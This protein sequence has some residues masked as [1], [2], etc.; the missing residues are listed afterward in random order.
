MHWACRS[1]KPWGGQKNSSNHLRPLFIY[2]LST[3]KETV[4]TMTSSVGSGWSFSPCAAPLELHTGA[5]LWL[6]VFQPLQV[7]GGDVEHD[8]FEPQD[9]KEALREGAVT[10]ALPIVACLQ[11]NKPQEEKWAEPQTAF[12]VFQA[13]LQL[14]VSSEKIRKVLP[15]FYFLA[16]PRSNYCKCLQQLTGSDCKLT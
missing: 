3:N 10:D 13:E 6:S 5:A 7:D 11:A 1:K 2:L 14:I 16:K 15:T 12:I 9:H 8:S 4:A